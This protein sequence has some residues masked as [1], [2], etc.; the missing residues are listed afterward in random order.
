M[1][2]KGMDQSVAVDAPIAIAYRASPFGVVDFAAKNPVIRAGIK[3]T[4]YA[5]ISPATLMTISK[6]VSSKM[7]ENGVE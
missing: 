5:T 2:S 7:L 1:L 6:P 4:R 3:P